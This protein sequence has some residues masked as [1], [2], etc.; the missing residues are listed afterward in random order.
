MK[1]AEQVKKEFLITLWELQN[2]NPSEEL[3]NFLKVKTIILADILD[4]D[5]PSDYCEQ[6]EEVLDD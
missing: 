2:T 5:F 3:K 4:D 6:F 1:T